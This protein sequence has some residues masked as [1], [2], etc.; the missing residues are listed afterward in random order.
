ML[1]LV[2][3]VSDGSDAV[4]GVHVGKQLKQG[5]RRGRTRIELCWLTLVARWSKHLLQGDSIVFSVVTSNCL[6]F[7]VL[8]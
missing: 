7:S 3:A 5:L 4:G 8:M 1:S 6:A 2:F